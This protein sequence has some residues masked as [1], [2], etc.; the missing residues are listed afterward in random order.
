MS[1]I[2]IT[3]FVAWFCG[4]LILGFQAISSLMGAED[5]MVWKSLA[6]VDVVGKNNFD[7]I[8]TLPWVILQHTV[9]YVVNMPLYLLLFCVGILCFLVNAFKPK[10]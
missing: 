10:I 1:K 5:E 2:T 6:L 8:K 7:W 4:G 9:T 3:G